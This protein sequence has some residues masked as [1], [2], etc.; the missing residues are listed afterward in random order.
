LF[1]ADSATRWIWSFEVQP[2]GSLANGEPF[3]GLELPLAGEGKLVNSWADGMTFDTDG[4]LY[5]A[6]KAGIQICDQAGRVFAILRKPSAADPS[7]VV[8]GGSD[9]RTLYVTAKDKVYRRR[10]QH[11][12]YLPWQPPKWPKPQL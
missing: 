3:Y 7:N 12:G 5:V 11:A 10:L 9:F 8:F 2:D 6:T 1:V 4:Y